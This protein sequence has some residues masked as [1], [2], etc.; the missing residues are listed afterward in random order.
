[1]GILEERIKSR[2]YQVNKDNIEEPKAPTL[3]SRQPSAEEA[4]EYL[5]ELDDYTKKNTGYIFDYNK[6]TI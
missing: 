4:T 2:Y 5:N 6:K 1:M 3:S